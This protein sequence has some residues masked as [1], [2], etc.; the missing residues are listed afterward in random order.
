MV[1]G[2]LAIA[3]SLHTYATRLA[4]THFQVYDQIKQRLE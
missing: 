3:S 2:E 4:N 1:N